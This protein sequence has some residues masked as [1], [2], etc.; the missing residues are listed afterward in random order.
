M[1]RKGS[2]RCRLGHEDGAKDGR[3]RA[4]GDGPDGDRT[5]ASSTTRADIVD[6]AAHDVSVELV[7]RLSF[8]IDGVRVHRLRVAD[9]EGDRFPV[10]VA[11]DAD[12]LV[13]I[14]TGRWY[15][16]RGM[17]GRRP[18]GSAVGA[19]DSA[20]EGEGFEGGSARDPVGRHVARAARRLDLDGPFGVV[21]EETSVTRA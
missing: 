7:S 1:G 6:G 9:L 5:E 4:P 16:V 13:D 19:T 14:G 15:H 21:T 3:I 11:P 17:V 8:E 20:S 2:P 12:P 18:G 10:L